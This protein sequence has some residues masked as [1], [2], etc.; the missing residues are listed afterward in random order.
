MKKSCEWERNEFG[1][2]NAAI[3]N[4]QSTGN[5]P[6][7]DFGFMLAR[8]GKAVNIA[9]GIRRSFMKQAGLFHLTMNHAGEPI[10][11]QKQG[12]HCLKA[13]HAI[14]DTRSQLKEQSPFVP[15]GAI[16]EWLAHSFRGSERREARLVCG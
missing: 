4:L 3:T 13:A 11:Q 6:V 16:E 5:Q 1:R 8:I 15:C 10:R 9:C 7:A 2:R 14:T 12:Q